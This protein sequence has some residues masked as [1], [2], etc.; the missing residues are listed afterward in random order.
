MLCPL[1]NTYSPLNGFF[2]Y[3]AQMITR[4]RWCVMHNDIWPLAISSMSFS[5]DFAIKLLKY[6]SFYCVHSTAHTVLDGFFPY[7]QIITSMRGCVMH[8]NLWP[9]SISSRSFSYEFAIQLLKY[10][11]SCHVRSIAH[12]GLDGFFP[13][14]AQMITSMRGCG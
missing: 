2:P 7:L 3:Q 5:Y 14:W 6:S 12:K 10:V 1:C 4:M 9:W 13:Y 11:T 8:N